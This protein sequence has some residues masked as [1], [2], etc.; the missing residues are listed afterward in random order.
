MQGVLGCVSS[1]VGPRF[2]VDVWGLCLLRADLLQQRRGV[3]PLDT[4]QGFALR[5]AIHEVACAS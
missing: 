1:G 5:R 4:T 2:G 3:G